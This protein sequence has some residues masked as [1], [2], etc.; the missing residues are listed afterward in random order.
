M[1]KIKFSHYY[2]KIPQKISNR[3][4]WL[5]AVQIYD[6][7]EQMPKEFLEYDTI[8]YDGFAKKNYPLPSGKVMLLVLF[9]GAGESAPN[10]FV[11]TTIRS[12]NKQKEQYYSK[13]VGK[14]VGIVVTE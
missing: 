8:Y 3:P 4:T 6:S 12:W 9:S 13:L 7:I 1:K 11:W 10:S 2:S 14:E 5:V